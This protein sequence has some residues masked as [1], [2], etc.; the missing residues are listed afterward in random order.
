MTDFYTKEFEL[1]NKSQ[2][3]EY[4]RQRVLGQNRGNAMRIAWPDIR[5]HSV[6]VEK[7]NII[8]RTQWFLTEFNRLLQETPLDEMWNGK[9]AIHKLLEVVESH[10]SNGTDKVKAIRDLNYLTRLIRPS[11]KP[12]EPEIM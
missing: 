3:T 9:L 12:T 4:A 8:E 6:D 7:I 11:D 5:Y 2:I 10:L 1:N